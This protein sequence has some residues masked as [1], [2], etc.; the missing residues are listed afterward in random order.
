MRAIRLPKPTHSTARL[1]MRSL[2]RPPCDAARSGMASLYRRP[3][4]HPHTAAL[5]LPPT[6]A[7]E[8]P[9][10]PA[11]DAAARSHQA[12]HHTAKQGNERA[13]IEPS[14]EKREVDV[15]LSTGN[16]HTHQG[17]VHSDHR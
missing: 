6:F 8:H 3:A 11:V 10:H 7:E 17:V 14:G 2:A 16:R 15:V 4:L 9:V 5:A 1:D 12:Q 13:G